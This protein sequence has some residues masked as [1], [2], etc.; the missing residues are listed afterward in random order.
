MSDQTD[1]DA[2]L[3]AN[4]NTIRQGME[5]K[6]ATI[7]ADLE[8]W[9]PQATNPVDNATVDIASLEVA[10][11]RYLAIYDGADALDLIQRAFRR[12]LAQRHGTM[13]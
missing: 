12:V 4:L 7:K 10:F 1:D 5:A 9:L 3:A 11:D 13:Q 8:Q 2:R 6:V